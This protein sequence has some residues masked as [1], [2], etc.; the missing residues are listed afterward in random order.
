M[1][2]ETFSMFTEINSRVQ[3]RILAMTGIFVIML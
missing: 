3:R 1:V 2:P